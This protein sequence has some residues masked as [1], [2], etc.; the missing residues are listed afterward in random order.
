MIVREIEKHEELI[1]KFDFFNDY[2]N[3]R[4]WLVYRKNWSLIE[5]LDS[6]Y[7]KWMFERNK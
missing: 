7:R 1:D 3:T 4:N 2:D 5:K 6:A